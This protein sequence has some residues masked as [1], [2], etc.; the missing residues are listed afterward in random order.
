MRLLHTML[1]QKLMGM[2]LHMVLHLM[3]RMATMSLLMTKSTLTL[4]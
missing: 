3:K 1:L 4:F 2:V